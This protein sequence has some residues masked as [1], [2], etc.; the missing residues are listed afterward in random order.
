MLWGLFSNKY[1]LS[2]NKGPFQIPEGIDFDYNDKANLELIKIHVKRFQKM[3][4]VLR[5]AY[6]GI[7]IGLVLGLTGWASTN[8]LPFTATIA[9][10][11]FSIATY[12]LTIRAKCYDEY[13]EALD[14]LKKIFQWSMGKETGNISEKLGIKEL[15]TLILVLGPWVD[16]KTICTWEPD[17][18]KPKGFSKY[19]NTRRADISE[20]FE[21]QLGRF[22]VGLQTSNWEYHLYGENGMK[23]ITGIVMTVLKAKFAEQMSKV[24]ERLPALMFEPG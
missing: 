2:S 6:Y 11:G 5:S 1:V 22:E 15:Q 18:L 13:C 21:R 23:E 19:M 8:F 12:C 20:E 4:E 16:S 10:L 14:D 24:P 7:V 3:Q 9:C 17:D